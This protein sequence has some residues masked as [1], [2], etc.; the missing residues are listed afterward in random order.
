MA[1]PDEQAGNR[2]H[3]SSGKTACMHG[4][5]RINARACFWYEKPVRTVDNR[6]SR[7]FESDRSLILIPQQFHIGISA[8]DVAKV[9]EVVSNIYASPLALRG[10]VVALPC[11]IKQSTRAA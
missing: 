11:A 9:R 8:N 7:R 6:E 5:A 4:Y 10:P 1:L 3:N 2:I